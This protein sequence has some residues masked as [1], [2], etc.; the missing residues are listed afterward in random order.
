MKEK[1]LP[2]FLEVRN[3]C[4]NFLHDNTEYNIKES[5]LWF[6]EKKPNFFLVEKSKQPIGYFRTSNWNEEEGS[7]WLGADL[8]KD[9]RGLGYSKTMY[10]QFF[11]ELHE[12]GYNIFFLDVLET[13]KRALN[14]YKKLGFKEQK[15]EKSTII[16]STG[17]I[18]KNVHMRL[19]YEKLL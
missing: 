7:L 10:E 5:L 16:R 11:E 8:H 6:K 17:E 4:R 2:F 18:H 12:K 3:E 14:L 1:D 9:F 19:N 15:T 13:N